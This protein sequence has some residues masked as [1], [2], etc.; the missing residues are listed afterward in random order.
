MDEPSGYVVKIL[1]FFAFQGEIDGLGDLNVL[2]RHPGQV[3]DGG[4]C[5]GYSAKLGAVIYVPLRTLSA[6]N[7]GDFEGVAVTIRLQCAA[8]SSV[9]KVVRR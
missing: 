1:L 9:L 7:K 4:L 6:V 8:I 5:C 2:N 3:C